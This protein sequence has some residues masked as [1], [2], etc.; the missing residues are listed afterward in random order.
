MPVFPKR[1]FQHG[2]VSADEVARLFPRD[3]AALPAP[4]PDA[5]RRRGVSGSA[6][7]RRIRALRPPKRAVDPYTAHGVAGRGGAP[8][9]RTRRAGAH[10]LPRRRRVSLHLLVLR[11]VAVHARRADA[12]GRARRRSSSACSPRWTARLPQR[13]KLYNASNFFDRRAVPREDYAALARLAAPFDGGDGRV[14]REHDRRRDARVRAPARRGPT[15][16]VASGSRRSIPRAMARLNKRLDLARL[17]RGDAV[18]RRR[19]DR[20]ARL[21]PARRAVRAGRRER[22]VDGAHGGARGRARRGRRRRS[23]RCAAATARWSGCAALGEFTPP[24]LCAARGSARRVRSRSAGTVVTADLW[25]VERLPA[26]DA[27]R[28]RAD[29]AAARLNRTGRASRGR[30]RACG[31]QT[32]CALG[33]RACEPCDA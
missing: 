9:G 16:E 12:A 8:P 4:L 5:A 15:L 26:C 17:R 25:D 32:P 7:D 30:L 23:S 28:T 19:G 27:C 6:A 10:G 13:L 3:E 1:R 2:S 29:R 20:S 18:S 11:P 22:R 14:A 33:R 31:V 24:T 21:R